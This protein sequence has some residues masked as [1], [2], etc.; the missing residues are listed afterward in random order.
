MLERLVFLPSM[1]PASMGPP[2]TNTVGIFSLAAAMRR[3]GTFLSQ[4]GTITRPSKPCARVIA[5]VE[6]AIISRVI[7]E[8][9]IPV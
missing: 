9:F 3:P 4:F 6:S 2:E 1:R 7:R 5:S 8:Y